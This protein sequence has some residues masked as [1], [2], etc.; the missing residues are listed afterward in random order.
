MSKTVPAI[1]DVKARALIAGSN[2][3]I[4]HAP[5]W[6][7]RRR[8]STAPSLRVVPA[9]GCPGTKRRCASMRCREI[10]DRTQA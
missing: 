1:R 4:S 6:P 10:A 5:C 9:S 7:S 3:S 8:S 2:F